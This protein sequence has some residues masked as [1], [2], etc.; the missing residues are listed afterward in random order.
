MINLPTL[1]PINSAFLRAFITD[2]VRVRCGRTRDL[3]PLILT[4]FVTFRCDMRCTYCD[5]TDHGYAHRFKEL[6]SEGAREV[7]R[8]CREGVPAVAFS[9]GEPLLRSDIVE[10]VRYA[11]TLGYRPISMFTNSLMLEEKQEVLEDI[12]YLQISLDTIDEELQDRLSGCRGAG[13]RI[14]NNIMRYAPLQKAKRFRLN[15]NCVLSPANLD[16]VPELLRFAEETGV[17]FTFSPQLEADGQAATVLHD[18]DTRHRYQ[19]AVAAILSHKRSTDVV[20]DIL[21]FIRHVGNF[22]SGSCYPM[23]TPRVYP[24]GTLRFP[25]SI[26]CRSAPSVPEL[27]SWRQVAMVL[28]KTPATCASPCLLPCYL[29][30]SLLAEHPFAL[31]Q[32][33]T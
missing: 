33:L 5:Y 9:G 1:P 31:L 25:C 8:I 16:S 4:Y 15:I 20:L 30:M 7:L 22:Q 32:E 13:R 11:R 23:L 24:D 14:V 29:E 10:L 27:G 21:P 3:R 26:V 19:R 28:R 2:A 17:R 12:D 18:P 6:E